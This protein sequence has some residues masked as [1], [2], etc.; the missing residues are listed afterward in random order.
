M[1]GMTLKIRP[2][3]KDKPERKILGIHY[4]FWL[5][6]ME[7]TNS[8]T[9]VHL[10]MGLHDANRAE[11]TFLLDG[12][13]VDEDVIAQLSA[14]VERKDLDTA[15]ASVQ[16][17]QRCTALSPESEARCDLPS[18]HEGAHTSKLS[19]SSRVSW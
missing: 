1:A 11:L 3:N 17:R 16:D 7:V 10:H 2:N 19:E 8:L 14:Y 9:E 13:D 15:I 5:N 18:G 12:V 4:Q 6:D